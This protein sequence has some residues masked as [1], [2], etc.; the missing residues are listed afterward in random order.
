VR[1]TLDNAPLVARTHLTA[2]NSHMTAV[3]E[4][5]V[6]TMNVVDG[7]A[8]DKNA[9]RFQVDTGPLIIPAWGDCGNVARRGDLAVEQFDLAFVCYNRL[10]GHTEFAVREP[11]RTPSGDIVWHYSRIRCIDAVHEIFAVD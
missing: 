9:G 7:A 10:R 4:Y 3:V 2:P 11:T 8:D 6:T 5:P 1:A